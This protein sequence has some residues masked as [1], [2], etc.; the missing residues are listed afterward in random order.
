[1]WKEM[2]EESGLEIK[3]DQNH[4]IHMITGKNKHINVN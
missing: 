3:L 2:T 4:S 1:M